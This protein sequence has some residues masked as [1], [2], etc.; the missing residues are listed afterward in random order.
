MTAAA[1]TREIADAGVGVGRLIRYD[2]R[3]PHGFDPTVGGFLRY[4]Q[5]RDSHEAT[6]RHA[7]VD[8]LLKYV[9]HRDRSSP[10]G[11][12]FDAQGRLLACEPRL[13]RVTRTEAD[14][15]VTVLTET[16][17]GKRWNGLHYTTEFKKNAREKAKGK[18]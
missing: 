7:K 18:K 13:R 1:I 16:F 4:I 9:A 5:H 3:W 6:P 17:D 12:L 8:S 2:E 10:R 14:G 11:R 15:T